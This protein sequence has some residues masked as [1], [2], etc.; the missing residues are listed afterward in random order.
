MDYDSSYSAYSNPFCG[1]NANLVLIVI[2]FGFF[3]VTRKKSES[4]LQ[5]AFSL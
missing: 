5:L 3:V 2:V 1:V 4:L